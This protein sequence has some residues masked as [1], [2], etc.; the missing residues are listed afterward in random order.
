M[1]SDS[2]IPSV[3][4]APPD[5]LAASGQS[6]VRELEAFLLDQEVMGLRAILYGRGFFLMVNLL[7]NLCLA[8]RIG[9]RVA[10]VFLLTALGGAIIGW[11]WWCL[12]HRRS[13]TLCGTLGALNDVLLLASLPWVWYLA[14][15]DGTPQPLVLLLKFPGFLP[16]C[17]TLLT[18]NGFAVRARYPLIIV[19]GVVLIQ[20][21]LYA[22]VRADPA[23]RLTG[24]A[25]EH[26]SS[27]ALSPVVPLITTLTFVLTGLTLAVHLHY[28]RQRVLAL[29]NLERTR[30]KLSRYFSPS[31]FAQIERGRE[32]AP[33]EVEA[34]ELSEA[35]V[36]FSD[37]RGF[38]ALSS[39][40]SP[41]EVVATLRDYHT[42]M[43]EVINRHG[44]TLDKYIGDGMM[45]IFGLPAPHP[46]DAWRAVQAALAMH[47]ALTAH[48][49]ER[50]ARGLP[51][52]EHTVGIHGGP[53]VA[54]NIGARSHLEYTVIGDTV[55]VAS[56][57]EGLC[58]TLNAKVLITAQV[59]G[60]LGAR[61]IGLTLVD[62]GEQ[63]LRGRE[64]AMHVFAVRVGGSTI[65]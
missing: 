14:Q 42:R 34:L 16:I 63:P 29:A 21:G 33:G 11:S 6:H 36:L 28:Q 13:V 35:V 45:A 12:T 41:A 24:V 44:G 15:S 58:R 19:A 10:A 62:H 1:H 3:L 47:E 22:V 38:T 2:T 17:F 23:T 64:G 51:A 48:N 50:T 56:R 59:V 4:Q 31:I 26:L 46:D 49:A 43:V 32:A 40:L 5:G 55:N 25:L 65:N 54:G 20:G 8:P 27:A 37:L 61:Q 18:L 57:V 9:W 7:I 30:L 52:L 53:L 60:Q 39:S